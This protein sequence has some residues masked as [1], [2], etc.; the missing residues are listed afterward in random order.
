MHVTGRTAG[1]TGSALAVLLSLGLLGTGAGSAFATPVAATDGESEYCPSSGKLP[2]I[3]NS[4]QFIDGNV[5]L[6]AGGDYTVDGA[7]AE[8][9]GLLVVKGDATFAKTSGGI[10][11]VGRAGAGSGILPDGGEVMLAVG[12]NLTIAKGTKVDVGHGVTSKSG[13]GGAVRVG[14][15][16]D[17]KG[18][19]ETNGGNRS[20]GLGTEG[21]LS[22]YQSFDRTI[23]DESSSLGKL[24]ATGT[25]VREG[26]T[27]TFKSTGA[28]NGGIQVFEI[29]A[30]E[31]DGASSFV[32]KSIPDGDSVAVNVTGSHAVSISPMSVGFN[33][34]RVDVYSSAGFGDAASR[35]LY[36]F[37]DSTSLTLGGGGNFMGSI[38]APRASADFTASTNGRV[39]VGGDVK[40]HGTGNESHNYPWNGSPAFTCKPEPS[41]PGTPTPKP[42][43][44]EQ[45]SQP[46]TGPGT[47]TPSAS[48][49]GTPTPEP[50]GSE[51][52]PTPVPT[53]S[54]PTSEPKDEGGFLAS[55]GAQVGVYATAAAVL[56]A[57]GAG[58]L[59]FTRR[60]RGQNQG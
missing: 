19:L 54:A 8:A 23:G 55:T 41:K 21:A 46:P 52:S 50:S 25:S 35:I 59:M 58:L 51:E 31:L 13:Y 1:R 44:P 4:P 40:T 26:G 47:P 38:L 14:K 48:Q 10:F 27:V 36:N 28:G 32:F 60:R 53:P 45:P 39:Y 20:S 12:G 7:S 2:G 30:A 57:L 3:G 22:P 29:P 11:N 33:D 42:S 17:E 16:I 49:P 18:E 43:E 56:G 15:K 34:D 24:K 37:E 9:E 6:F 5:A